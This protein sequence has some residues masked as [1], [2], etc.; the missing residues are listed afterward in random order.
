VDAVDA[1]T[2]HRITTTLVAA[3]Q[4][5]REGGDRLQVQSV[6]DEERAR[7]RVIVAGGAAST[8]GLL[9]LVAALAEEE[10]K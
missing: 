7:L 4:A 9:R 8:A 6:Y 3:A 10:E 5:P 2:A 1:G